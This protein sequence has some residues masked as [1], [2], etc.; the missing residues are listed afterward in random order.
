MGVSEGGPMSLLFAATY[1]ERTRALVVYGALPRFNRAPGFPWGPT[2][3]EDV[4]ESDE[5]ARRWGTLELARENLGTEATED[6]VRTFA[7]HGRL[8]ATPSDVA[9]SGG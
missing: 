7:R 6:E 2:Y 3:E 5:Y 1:L 4:R 9:P 8:S